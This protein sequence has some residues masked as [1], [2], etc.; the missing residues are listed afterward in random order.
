MKKAALMNNSDKLHILVTGAA[1]G[2]GAACA[3]KL[4]KPNNVLFLHTGKNQEKLECLVHE[5]R[6]QKG[7]EIYCYTADFN[8]PERLAEMIAEIK[9]KAGHI[10]QLVL[11]AGYA[12][13]GDFHQLTTEKLST[14]L[15]VMAESPALL[16]KAFIQDI[17]NSKRGRIVA[18]SSFVNKAIGVNDTA[19]TITAAAK[20]ALEGLTMEAARQFQKSQA[21]ANIISPGYTRKDSGKSAFSEQQWLELAAKLPLGRLVEPDEVAAL[22]QFLLSEEAAMITGQ[23]ISIDSGLNL[24]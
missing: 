22:V 7:V 21:T 18:I 24:L 20:S 11:N 6:F 13:K 16:I 2:I 4:T 10:D 8:H 3:R 14:A 9:S 5:L 15:A 12:D 19:F 1:S 23:N 17:Q